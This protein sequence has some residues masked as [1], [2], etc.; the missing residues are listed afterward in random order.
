[1]TLLNICIKI[2]R[3]FAQSKNIPKY[4]NIVEKRVDCDG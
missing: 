4:Q 3:L 1:M 2:K